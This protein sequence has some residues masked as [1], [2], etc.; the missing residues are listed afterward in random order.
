MGG[1]ASCLWI[2]AA[3]EELGRAAHHHTPHPKTR[4][5]KARLEIGW[6]FFVIVAILGNNTLHAHRQRAGYHQKLFVVFTS[7]IVGNT[8][9][10]CA[11]G[12]PSAIIMTITFN[13]LQSPTARFGRVERSRAAACGM[14]APVCVLS[15]SRLSSTTPFLGSRC[16]RS[17]M[18]SSWIDAAK[19]TGV[20]R[21]RRYAV[22]AEG[23]LICWAL[24]SVCW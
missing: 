5:P 11:T 6:T 9:P 7:S 13:Q 24:S 12:A 14:P 20:V 10:T 19:P 18:V 1:A 23:F 16:M 15:H 2:Q 21:H 17:S 22:A 3:E 4:F 8:L